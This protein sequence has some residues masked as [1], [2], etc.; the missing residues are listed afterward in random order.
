ME[1]TVFNLE[2]VLGPEYA[3]SS[4]VSL[5]KWREIGT[6]YEYGSVVAERFGQDFI[7][8]SR[9]KILNCSFLNFN[10]RTPEVWYT[11]QNANHL[12]SPL[13]FAISLLLFYFLKLLTAVNLFSELAALPNFYVSLKLNDALVLDV[14]YWKQMSGL[15]DLT[16][17][18]NKNKCLHWST[19]PSWFDMKTHQNHAFKLFSSHF[20]TA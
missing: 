5:I 17:I 10:S 4:G 12:I 3:S 7:T 18:Q 20:S 8:P 14:Q 19:F 9:D 6:E 11:C 15:V 2:M 13:P 1:K 16:Q